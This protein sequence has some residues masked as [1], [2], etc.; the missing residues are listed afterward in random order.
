MWN[1][2]FKI[3]SS[4]LFI[5][6]PGIV[7]ERREDMILPLSGE[8]EVISR[9]TLDVKS[10][11][12]EQLPAPLIFRHVIRHHSMEI[13]FFENVL[14]RCSQGLAHQAFSCSAVIQTISEIG[15]LKDSVSYVAEVHAPDKRTASVSA[16]QQHQ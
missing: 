13:P 2:H 15:S 6:F 11:S 4:S 12:L 14:D 8:P 1:L 9:P 16:I 10:Q 5:S 7:D 3:A